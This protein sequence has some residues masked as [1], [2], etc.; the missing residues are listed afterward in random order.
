MIKYLPINLLS[1]Q[2]KN[3]CLHG[4][5]MKKFS[6]LC[7]YKNYQYMLSQ[8]K[9]ISLFRK[10]N[11]FFQHRGCIKTVSFCNS[12]PGKRWIILVLTLRPVLENILHLLH[13]HLQNLCVLH[14]GMELWNWKVKVTPAPRNKLACSKILRSNVCTAYSRLYPLAESAAPADFR[15]CELVSSSPPKVSWSKGYQKENEHL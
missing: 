3:I 12:H 2:F 13:C 7:E 6:V 14:F 15:W 5:I 11:L 10:K 1:C 9:W 8:L 4:P